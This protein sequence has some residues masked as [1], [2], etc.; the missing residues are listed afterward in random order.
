MHFLKTPLRPKHGGCDFA[1]PDGLPI[2]SPVTSLRRYEAT[3][4]LGRS[5]SASKVSN[6]LLYRCCFFCFPCIPF[7]SCYPSLFLCSTPDNIAA[8][9][10]FVMDTA[11]IISSPMSILYDRHVISRDTTWR[12]GSFH[13]TIF[14]LILVKYSP[15]QVEKYLWKELQANTKRKITK[16]YFLMLNTLSRGPG[17]DSRYRDFLRAVR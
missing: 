11:G 15:I 16:I 14:S 4:L 7:S 9:F 3:G 13:A 10:G 2:G 12:R 5:I 8:R 1:S 6:W 17:Y